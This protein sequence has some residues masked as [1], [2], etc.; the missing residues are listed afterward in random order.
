[1]MLGQRRVTT[2]HLPSRHFAFVTV[3]KSFLDFK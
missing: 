3:D 2:S 1:L